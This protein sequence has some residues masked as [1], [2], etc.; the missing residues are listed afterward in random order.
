MSA[1]PG[2]P[3]PIQGLDA[4]DLHTIGMEAAASTCPRRSIQERLA[5][6]GADEMSPIS[7]EVFQAILGV[8]LIIHDQQNHDARL[9]RIKQQVSN[10]KG[11]TE[12][13][14]CIFQ[15]HQSEH[16]I[17]PVQSEQASDLN[18]ICVKHGI[19]PYPNLSLYPG[20]DIQNLKPHQL[21]DAAAIVDRALS[22][23]K[24]AFLS[25]DAG[26][27]K[28]KTYLASLVLCQRTLEKQR[29]EGLD[30][31]FRPS[32]ILTTPKSIY[33]VFREIKWQ[34]PDLNLF[35]YF[36]DEDN[37]PDK[38]AKV[39]NS[40]S[41]VSL[42]QGLKDKAHQPDTGRVVILSTYS[43]WSSRL[44]H[45]T[46]R[47]FSLEQSEVDC[48]LRFQ[49]V[50][51]DEAHAARRLNSPYNNMLRLIEWQS[52]LWVSATPVTSSFRDL[53]S[54]L[55]L[56]WKAYGLR[57]EPKI[58]SIEDNEFEQG[59]TQGIFTDNYV[60]KYP[61]VKPLKEIFEK[62]Q[63]RL[64]MINSRLFKAAGETLQWGLHTG[65]LVVRPVYEAI[66]V[67][68]TMFSKLTLPDGSI[69][70][71]AEGL[72][73][74]TIVVEDL[75]FDALDRDNLADIV[76]MKGRAHAQ[77][78]FS[79][80]RDNF[81]SLNTQRASG[82]HVVEGARGSS[83]ATLNVEEHR[84][85]VLTAFDYRN[86][87][88]LEPKD[89]Y[90]Y[91]EKRAVAKELASLRGQDFG[92]SNSHMERQK[93]GT[94]LAEAPGVDIERIKQ[95]IREDTNCGLNYYYSTTRIDEHMPA[96]EGRAGW[97]RWLPGQSPILTR[98]LQLALRYC[99][100]QRER[101]L[102]YVDDP[103]IQC[104]AVAFFTIAG[105]NVG[106]VRS[107]D[108]VSARNKII[109]DWND[110]TSDLH[111]F[112]ANIDTMK[113][114]DMHHC[115]SKGAFF[116]W[117]LNAR[118]MRQAI[119]RPIRINQKKEVM[120]HILK[121]KNSYH[122]HIER[123]CITKWANQLSAKIPLPGWMTDEIREICVFEVIK[124][125]WH[126]S[127]NRYAWV[128]EYDVQGH[129]LEYHSDDVI[130]LG[131][132]FS[133]VAKLLLRCQP[134]D[135]E[136]WVKHM[137]VL[138][139]GCRCAKKQFPTVDDIEK[140]LRYPEDSLRDTFMPIFKSAM[141]AVTIQVSMDD[142]VAQRRDQQRQGVQARANESSAQF[143]DD[144]GDE[145]DDGDDG[146]EHLGKDAEEEE[147]KL[148][149]E[150]DELLRPMPR[151]NTKR[152]AGGGG[153]TDAEKKQKVAN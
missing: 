45:K 26:T 55:S 7:K 1:D 138:V 125:Y 77:R 42:I 56:M 102:V 103:W 52:I 41:L 132:I 48:Q 130:R 6:Y 120:F 117:H 28:T 113:D 2:S 20:E 57:W 49:F 85:G 32:L 129:A 51:A 146:S 142:E 64:W 106:T 4:V 73:L 47:Q 133:V 82:S 13:Q 131:H 74:P 122:D 135:E 112:V 44:T 22:P 30:V 54:P 104:I 127:F 25:S 86:S 140:Y 97:L 14:G 60:T 153:K 121:V 123:I 95:L 100:E 18:S 137:P 61:E 90:Y 17:T 128:V 143:F 68:T 81:P 76:E 63:C 15:C 93:K 105:F 107:C 91:G 139:E 23:Y 27:G 50:I 94:D 119:G 58:L 53:L 89:P 62:H 38:N 108:K 141:Q 36:R 98:G 46:R 8:L 70:Y 114:V 39:V 136:F 134:E 16:A 126:Q 148:Q 67:R 37:F 124:A 144:S 110:P 87:M 83:K 99:R 145:A 3:K 34:F 116:G 96:P 72:L 147:R 31:Q 75:N 84:K 33:Q 150:I 151:A 21:V 111:I 71:P 9:A 43:T 109:A 24:Q 118:G 115:C 11:D 92:L 10:L 149:D 59:R 40:R 88:I 69:S 5:S 35:V 19:S 66:Q 80:S 65:Q 12:L 101:F 79:K 78:A 152:K 29:N